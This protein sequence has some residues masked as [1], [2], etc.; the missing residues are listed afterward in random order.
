MINIINLLDLTGLMDLVLIWI[1]KNW[2]LSVLKIRWKNTSTLQ[3]LI[4]GYPISNDK[5][6][7]TTF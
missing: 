4:A 5:M 3:D 2:N 1:I 6:K 7:R